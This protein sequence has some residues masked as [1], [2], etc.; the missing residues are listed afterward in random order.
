LGKLDT[1]E[2]VEVATGKTRALDPNL[3]VGPH[4]IDWSPDGRTIVFAGTGASGRSEVD[5]ISVADESVRKLVSAPAGVELDIPRWSPNGKRL[6]Y[7][8][9][10]NRTTFF[11]LANADGS[12]ARRLIRTDAGARANWS[13]DGHRLVYGVVD[14]RLLNLRTGARRKIDLRLCRRYSCQD[15]DWSRTRQ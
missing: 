10:R 5:A 4:S 14:I 15:L 1:I 6:L 8:W 13:W 2:I 7:T 3:F 9:H 12:K 11:Y